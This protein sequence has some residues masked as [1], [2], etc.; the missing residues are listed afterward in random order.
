M[1][2]NSI[3]TH[4]NPVNIH[5]NNMETGFPCEIQSHNPQSKE[6]KSK[7]GGFTSGFFQNFTFWFKKLKNGL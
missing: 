4:G 5:V 3:N 1:Y 7:F 6:K 2:G